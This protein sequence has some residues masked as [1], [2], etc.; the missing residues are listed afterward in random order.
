MSKPN[1]CK[2]P[3]KDKEVHEYADMIR[4]MTDKQIWNEGH[5][6]PTMATVEHAIKE[7]FEDILAV[8][9]PHFDTDMLDYVAS[10]LGNWYHLPTD[11]DFVGSKQAKYDAELTPLEDDREVAAGKIYRHFKGNYYQVIDLAISSV[12]QSTFVVYRR[13]DYEPGSRLF[14]RP[15]SDFTSTVDHEKY[16]RFAEIKWRFTRVQ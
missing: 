5:R 12:D 13:L 6:Q 1:K 14:V 15:L 4:H 7:M 2:R 9:A 3:S 8:L 10:I 11:L 16:P